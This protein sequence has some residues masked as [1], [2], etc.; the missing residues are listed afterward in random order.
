MFSGHDQPTA[1]DTGRNA[2]GTDFRIKYQAVQLA[3]RTG[4]STIV[5]KGVKI[6]V[7]QVVRGL[8]ED[9]E[10]EEALN[11]CIQRDDI[12][13]DDNVYTALEYEFGTN[14]LDAFIDRLGQKELSDTVVAQP[15][16][17]AESRLS[18]MFLLRVKSGI[19]VCILTPTA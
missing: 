5:Q 7:S 6:N 16:R 2:S 14:I 4:V 11:D 9:E 19:A 10:R 12:Q 3:R 17:D 18:E 13:F 1:T 15:A 8:V